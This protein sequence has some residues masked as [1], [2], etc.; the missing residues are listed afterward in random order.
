MKPY[1]VILLYPDYLP[2][3]YRE[4][5]FTA[6]VS[7][8]DGDAAVRAAQADAVSANTD[9]D[10]ETRCGDP[11]DFAVIAVYAGHLEQE[12]WG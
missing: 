11:S 7:A 6:H 10:G 5:T 4:E 3:N 9:D 2:D 12:P 8:I 1:T